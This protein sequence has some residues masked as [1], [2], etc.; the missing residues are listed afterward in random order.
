MKTSVGLIESAK[1][2]ELTTKGVLQEQQINKQNIDTVM[3]PSHTY[4][5]TTK[6]KLNDSSFCKH[7]KIIKNNDF[8]NCFYC[9]MQV[10]RVTIFK[11]YKRLNYS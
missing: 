5:S 2:E 9:G 4:G 6:L 3:I 8:D 1:K 7:A 10:P 11:R